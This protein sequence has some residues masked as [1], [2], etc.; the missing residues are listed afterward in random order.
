MLWFKCIKLHK[1]VAVV[2]RHLSSTNHLPF[3]RA[4]FLDLGLNVLAF[5]SDTLTGPSESAVDD[6]TGG[7]SDSPGGGGFSEPSPSDRLAQHQKIPNIFAQDRRC[8]TESVSPIA[9]S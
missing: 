9:H 4:A 5:L 2:N 1:F 3:P 7:L 8:H 6:G